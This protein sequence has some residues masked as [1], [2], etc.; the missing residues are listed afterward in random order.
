[1]TTNGYGFQIG[2]GDGGTHRTVHFKCVNCGLCEL[3]F[4]KPFFFSK[5]KQHIAKKKVNKQE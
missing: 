5:K 3:Y 1:M 4:Q 2:C